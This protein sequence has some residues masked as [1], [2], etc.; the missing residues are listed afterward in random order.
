MTILIA[1]HRIGYGGKGFYYL[2]SP[3]NGIYELNNKYNGGF[4][5]YNGKLSENFT[6]FSNFGVAKK[7]YGY[8][9]GTPNTKPENFF[10][11]QDFAD[12]S[13]DIVQ[14]EL[15][16]TLNLFDDKLR[17]LA[18]AQGKNTKI[19]VKEKSRADW[20]TKESSASP[21]AQAEFKPIDHIL[22]IAGLRND[23]FKTEDKKMSRTSPNFGISIFPFANTDYDYTTIWSSYSH[24][25]RTPS[26]QQRFL[27]KMM[28]GNPNL[29]PE[30][31]KGWEAGVK[32]RLSDWGSV[33]F[34]YF[35]TDYKEMIRLINLGGMNFLFKNE[36]Q[37]VHKGFELSTE[38]Y[39]T[40]WLGLIASYSRTKRENSNGVRLLGQPD[41]MLKYGFVISDIPSL[42][43]LSLSVFAKN[44]SDFKLANGSTHPS[45]K[46]TVM[47]A[48]MAYK[49]QAGKF[50]IEPF[51][52][53]ENLTDKTYYNSSPVGIAQSRAW[54]V[55]ANMRYN[56]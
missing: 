24:A 34:S 23:S 13:E 6:L 1:T 17:I 39:P 19:K 43:G 18:G 8:I 12:H 32:Q 33:E 42:D 7:D 26:F 4:F 48:R 56:F 47:D 31:A 41:T 28:G 55:G 11:K 22:L 9:S 44:L 38:I 29:K 37:A 46:K 2:N 25:F 16:G 21:F 5:T 52:Q 40:N 14:G 27:P 51:A 45:N 20:S 54:K 35:K 3:W 10:A 15:R 53:I 36:D 49:F 30:I 50:V